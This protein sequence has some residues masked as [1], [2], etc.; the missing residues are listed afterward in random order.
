MLG[1]TAHAGSSA[2]GEQKTAV[3]LVNFQDNPT[4]PITPA[5]ANSTVFGEV[6]DFYWEA[7]YE[8]TFL[9]GNTYGWYTVPVSTATCDEN[10][11]AREA[12]AAAA[13]AGVDLTPYSKVVYMFP[14]VAA[15]AWGGAQDVGDR[16]EDR[17]FIN[18]GGFTP[19]TIAHELGHRFGLLHSDSWD[20]GATVLGTGCTRRSYFDQADTMGNRF[21]HFNAFQKERLGWFNTAN[22]PVLREVTASGR[23]AMEPYETRTTGVKALKFL[24]DIDP[25][26]GVKTWYYIEYRQ[27]VGFD[28]SIDSE[29]NLTKG[30]LVHTGGLNQWG[31]PISVLLDM[32]PA[33]NSS[34]P[35]DVM[36][37]ALEVGRSF[38]D[39]YT[40]TS[41]TLVSADATGAV[42]DVTLASGTTPSCTRA[43]P[44]LTIAGPT[45][46][47]AAGTT[48]TYTLTVANRDSSECGAT[49]FSLASAV[50]SSW[51]ATLGATTVNLSP[52]ASTNTTLKV[53]SPTTAAAGSYSVGA[54]AS[55]N[56]GSVHTANASS[57][58]T[59]AVAP[60]LS[61]SLSTDKT[62][63]VRGET[64]AMTARVLNAGNPVAGAS[65]RFAVTLPG[66]STSTVNAVT[67]SDGVA[68]GTYKT[69][70]GK[71]AV[72]A[73][74][75]RADASSGGGNATANAS[76]NV[77]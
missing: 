28:K 71:A 13:A 15:C 43:A 34:E 36:D 49:G 37:G 61:G 66:G 55:S 8:K 18:Q 46:G 67:A 2:I 7:S 76:F 56:V 57:T 39:P 58:Y 45:S 48:N 53:T 26:T 31:T 62:S 44:A 6:S 77:R 38:V 16:G 24:K 33:S 52:G 19:Q 50:P 41:I 64:V 27:P 35:Y 75:V 51:S 14:K 59:V 32:T 69:G 30:V 63:Y 10:G 65:V 9:S 1:G 29:T 54:G 5:E 72:G 42:V 11:I 40:G 12:N 21:A 4:Q 70:K 22:G 17:V 20:C 60:A 23:Y 68:R 74:A 3:I 73:Y 25:A 47:V